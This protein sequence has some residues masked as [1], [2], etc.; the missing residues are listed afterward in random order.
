MFRIKAV[1]FVHIDVSFVARKNFFH[2]VFSREKVRSRGTF[3]RGNVL[4]LDTLMPVRSIHFPLFAVFLKGR[5][6]YVCSS[7]CRSIY[8]KSSYQK[9]SSQS[10]E[11]WR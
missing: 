3:Q 4:K 5:C 7:N 9:S 2:Q 10:N 11:T 1:A 6:R 8:R